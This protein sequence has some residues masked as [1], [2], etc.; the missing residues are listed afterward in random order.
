VADGRPRVAERLPESLPSS[1]P[2]IGLSRFE[3]DCSD[4]SPVYGRA[5][6]ILAETPIDM[7]R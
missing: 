7:T 5:E 2:T 3:L 1:L 6:E 4:S